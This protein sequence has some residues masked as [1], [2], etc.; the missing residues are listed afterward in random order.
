MTLL[1]ALQIGFVGLVVIAAAWTVLARQA[2]SAVVAF[3]VYGLLLALVWLSLGAP[4]VALTEAAIG[5]GLTG[6]LLLGA[7]ATLRGAKDEGA[8]PGVGLRLAAALVCGVVTVGL[9]VAVLGLPEPAP[10]LAPAA[11]AHLAAT[12]L[13][14]PVTAVLLAYRAWDTMLEKVVLVLALVGVWSLAPDRRWGGRPVLPGR[15]D[16]DGVLVFLARVLPPM[17]LVV[18]IYIFWV[19]A[20]DAGGAFP[21]ATILAAMGLLTGMAGL[22]AVPSMAQPA[23]RRVVVLGALVFLAVGAAGFVV[24]GAFLAYPVSVAKPLILVIEA[25]LIVSVA[26][27]LGLL[28]AGPPGRKP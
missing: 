19:G 14:N 7:C 6:A 15:S 12:G 24:P 28:V 11:R 27:T 26:A 8:S 9:V 21:S 10:S 16:P 18:A 20:T 1:L 17:G 25:A 3:V 13:E 22:V 5:A 4:D 23:L 2:F